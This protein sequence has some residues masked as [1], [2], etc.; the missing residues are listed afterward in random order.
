MQLTIN[1]KVTISDIQ[2]GF[3]EMFPFLR[4][5]FFKTP[6]K[7][8]EGSPKKEILPVTTKLKEVKHQNGVMV[9]SEN[10]TVSELEEFFKNIF[11]LN[12]QVFRKSGNSWLETT[13]T[14]SWT[15]KKQ[16]QEGKELSGL[17]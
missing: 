4:I 2:K 17:G 16:N 3:E 11:N 5:Q 13:L 14:D 1:D 15:L 12:V 9:I 6:H 10:I 7:A 8:F